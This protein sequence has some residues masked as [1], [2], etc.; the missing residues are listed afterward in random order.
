MGGGVVNEEAV[1]TGGGGGGADSMEVGL[2]VGAMARA[3][4]GEGGAE[5]TRENGFGRMDRGRGGVKD[6]V[7]IKGRDGV[8]DK[9]GM[10]GGKDIFVGVGRD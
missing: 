6:R 5:R 3:E 2:E 10:E 1:R 7:G 4:L 9:G 8:L